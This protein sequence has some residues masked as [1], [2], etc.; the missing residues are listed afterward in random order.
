MVVLL[1][2]CLWAAFKGMFQGR[3]EFETEELNS[4]VYK[5]EL[6]E[7]ERDFSRGI[8]SQ[9]ELEEGKEELQR[10]ALEEVNDLEKKGKNH[11]NE[12]YFF[13]L[14]SVLIPVAALS[15]YFIVGNPS[16]IAYHADA[17]KSHWNEKGEVS[18]DQSA[19]LEEKKLRTYLKESPKDVRAWLTL[20]RMLNEKKQPKEALQAFNKA[21]VLSEKLAEDPDSVMER[22]LT[23][24]ETGDPANYSEAKRELARVIELNSGT[25]RP[26]EIL[27]ILSFNE[28]N[29]DEAVKYWTEALNFYPENS[30]TRAY[31][32][33][34]I[35]EAKNR[36]SLNLMR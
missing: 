14:L 30:A 33:D 7:L 22:A 21:F 24:L 34:V 6:A 12:K 26:Y 5:D 18:F 15:I 3:Q 16:L 27:G 1:V 25:V 35:S 4:Y 31:L 13:F 23:M 17:E 10:R 19:P 36:A 29:Y 28:G 32:L 20:A 2:V 11:P 9:E 8:I